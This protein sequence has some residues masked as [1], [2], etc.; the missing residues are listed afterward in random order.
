MSGGQRSAFANE[1]AWVRWMARG[2]T[3]RMNY[4]TAL[5][6]LTAWARENSRVRALVMTGS[7]GAGSPHPLSDRDLEVFTEDVDALLTDETWWSGLGDVLVVERLENGEG[8]ATRLIYYAGGKLDFTILPAASLSDRF[9]DRPF[10]VLVDKEARATTNEA[11]PVG[12]LPPDHAEFDESVNWAYAA[13]LMC[14]KA[15]VRDEMW[16][17]KMRDNDLKEQLL[18]M[19]EW[20]HRTRLGADHDTRYLGTRMTQWMDADVRDD[21]SS[22]WGRFD[23][24]DSAAALRATLRLYARIAERTASA[25]DFPAFHHDRI[26]AEVNGVLSAGD[27]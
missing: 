18:Q 7:G 9:Y 23:A 3:D 21:L 16:A 19:L 2:E 6:A 24:A 25:H 10:R 14:A 12:W 20:D 17:A 8:D 26:L 15:I 22:C 11:Q 1:R 27:L 4:E 5:Q 13:S